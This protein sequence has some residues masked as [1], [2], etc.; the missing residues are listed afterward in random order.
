[1]EAY[2]LEQYHR[3]SKCLITLLLFLTCAF[4]IAMIN[5]NWN[6]KNNTPATRAEHKYLANF[7]RSLTKKALHFFVE[8]EKYCNSNMIPKSFHI[9]SGNIPSSS[10]CHCVPDTLAGTINVTFAAPQFVDLQRQHSELISGGS[11]TPQ[12]CV[13]RHRVAIIIPYRDREL[14][15]RKLLAI[16]HPMLQRQMLQY[17]IFVVE[18][19]QPPTFNRAALMNVGFVEARASANFDCFIFHD[20]DKLPEDDRDF[21]VC[22]QQRRHVSPYLS[23]HRYRMPYSGFFGGV[24]ALTQPHFEKTNGFSNL[25][26]GWGGEDDDMRVR[27]TAKHMKIVRFP[28]DVS[29]HT[30]ISHRRD[31]GNR[32]NPK[33]FLALRYAYRRN[34]V[35]GLNSLQYSLVVKEQRLLYT[36]LLVNLLPT[37]IDFKG[38][39]IGNA[40]GHNYGIRANARK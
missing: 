17:S 18:Q 7:K 39:F 36:W 26:Y 10:L 2:L 20:V 3:R 23:K 16:L 22:L 34:A 12:S 15:L 21:Y 8:Y 32:A 25:Y 33:R 19:K 30:V 5:K 13:P 38:N 1:M 40:S 6:T 29:R 11:W 28:P 4:V 35:D 9:T 27:V 24:I 31:V 14:H 37:P